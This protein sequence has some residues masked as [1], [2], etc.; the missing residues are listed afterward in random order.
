MSRWQ[1]AHI[2]REST[3]VS[4]RATEV[5]KERLEELRRELRL[6]SKGQVL[7]VALDLLEILAVPGTWVL[8]G[9]EGLRQM[10]QDTE[11]TR[12]KIT[13]R[14][15]LEDAPADADGGLPAAAPPRAR[16]DHGADHGQDES[17]E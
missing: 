12:A 5:E 15:G 3:F 16:A 2:G 7:R 17:E 10:R 6:T 4:M 13:R 14:F 9:A 1:D 8:E 11:V